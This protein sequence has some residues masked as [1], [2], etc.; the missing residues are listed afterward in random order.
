MRKGAS[1]KIFFAL[2]FIL[3]FISAGFSGE[4]AIGVARE[5]TPDYWKLSCPYFK[6]MASHDIILKTKD[7]SAG[8]EKI[9]KLSS[10]YK[11]S[12]FRVVETPR[13]SNYR[14]EDPGNAK[15]FPVTV[16]F[17]FFAGK[18]GD[19]LKD[20]LSVGVMKKYSVSE[21]YKNFSIAE[22]N[23][24][25]ETVLEELKNINE[26]PK[27]FR[28]SKILMEDLEKNIGKCIKNYEDA[29]NKFFFSV[30]L[31]SEYSVQW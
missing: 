1:M 7:V 23:S 9:R 15:Q 2:P 28:V 25:H 26:Y 11:I 21:Y 16:Q 8:A 13:S 18:E 22:F 27:K 20:L 19:F 29:K 6:Q 3:L 14:M 5:D 10:K 4:I 12:D 31:V 17:Y 24:K 30:V